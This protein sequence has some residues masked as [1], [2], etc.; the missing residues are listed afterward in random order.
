M[1]DLTTRLTELEL[2]I[3]SHVKSEKDCHWVCVGGSSLEIPLKINDSSFQSTELLIDFS[4]A[5][6]NESLF[7]DLKESHF[8]PK[9][10]LIC[11]TGVS[12]ENIT[13]WIRLADEHKIN[14]MFAANTS[15]GIALMLK[16][17]LSIA[18]QFLKRG[19]DVE[20]EET[21]HKMKI[22]SPSGTASYLA[23]N[24]AEENQ[25]KIINSRNAPREK[26]ELGIHSIRGGGVYGE[27][28][29]RFLGDHEELVITHK[30]Y[31]RNLFAAGTF[32]LADW[33]SE[34]E[35]GFYELKDAFE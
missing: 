3:S 35:S 32:V 10:I 28:K 34:Q 27:H 30:A 1:Q 25:L 26:R 5:K 29:V 14:L 15:L 23:E 16:S 20:I 21:H 2:S 33:L 11:T 4:S 17:S 19:F 7:K 18:P 12:K 8:I 24:L 6:A 13:S 31:S 9:N 22:D